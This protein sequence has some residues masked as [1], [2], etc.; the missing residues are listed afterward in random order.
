MKRQ[1]FT[2]IELLIVIA[3]I[4]ILALIALPNFLEAQVRGKIARVYA[5]MRSI[6]VAIEAYA[7]DYGRPPIAGDREG[8]PSWGHQHYYMQLSTP[9]AYLSVMPFEPFL[10]QTRSRIWADGSLTPTAPFYRAATVMPKKLNGNPNDAVYVKLAAQSV[11][12]WLESPGPTRAWVGW[13]PGSLQRPMSDIGQINTYYDPTNGSM[14]LGQIVR[15][16]RG[17]EPIPAY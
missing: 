9:V 2:L 10:E 6:G 16:N 3:I 8:K 1:A 4:A 14:S 13:I 5:D 12:W 11:R 17:Q 7:V 15:T